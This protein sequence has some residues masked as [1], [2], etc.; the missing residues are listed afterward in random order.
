MK[1]LLAF[2]EGLFNDLYSSGIDKSLLSAKDFFTEEGHDVEILGAFGDHKEA[3][4]HHPEIG[5]FTE[6]KEDINQHKDRHAFKRFVKKKVEEIEPELIIAFQVPY[7]LDNYFH[8]DGIPLIQTFNN[9]VENYFSQIT[10]HKLVERKGH[11]VMTAACQFHLD[12]MNWVFD[13][14]LA[15]R[16]EEF[17]LYKDRENVF[18]GI[19]HTDY[20]DGTTPDAKPSQDFVM[21]VGRADPKKKIFLGHEFSKTPSIVFTTKMGVMDEEYFDKFKDKG[22]THLDQPHDRI[23]KKLETAQCEILGVAEYDS[24][25]IT[26]MEACLRGVPILGVPIKG[27]HPV[28]YIYPEWGYRMVKKP[29]SSNM[30]QAIKELDLSLEQRKELQEYARS[31]YSKETYKAQWYNLI[32][33]AM[34]R[35]K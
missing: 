15:Y 26:T 17:P 12:R 8:F 28:Q 6:F 16:P 34:E 33:I 2:R 21:S 25:Q 10:F 5:S 20:D 3:H 29:N 7:R 24:F 19:I 30:N 9:T 4:I 27:L 1:I 14:M 31:Y 35:V 18:D 13:K 32:D 11:A 23:M 22:A